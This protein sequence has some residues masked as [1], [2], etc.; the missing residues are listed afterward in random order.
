[1]T[2]TVTPV[3]DAPVAVNDTVSTLA[4]T[5]VNIPVL[6][7]DADVDGP[8]L[9]VASITQPAHGTVTLISELTVRYTPASAYKG[10]DSFTYTVSDGAGGTATATV[11]VTVNAP[12]R[13]ATN[14]QVLYGFNE[15]SGTTVTDTSG[16]GTPLNLTIGSAAAV[17]WISGGLQVNAAT[18][19]QSAG[20][21]TKVIN[22]AQSSNEITLEAWVNPVNTSQATPI[23]TLSQQSNKLNAALT[24][25]GNRWSGKLR[26]STTNQAGTALSSAV[27]TATLNLTHVVYTR[28]AAGN[29]RIYVNG[30]QSATTTLTGNF[31]TWTNTYKLGLVNELSSGSPWLG[32]LYLVAVY[33]RSLSATEVRQN[34]L[35]GE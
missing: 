24:Q 9:V 8:S 33:S 20:A 34:W 22:A 26:T 1:V 3:N 4:E 19:I 32:K 5:A 30:V 16:V 23:A 35:A 25:G 2:V 10:P 31:S 27:G 13:I 18:L 12:P 21:A 29:V 14:L 6:T 11:N 15:G 7:N 28:D 17:T